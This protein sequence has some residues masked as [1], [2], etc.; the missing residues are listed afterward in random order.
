MAKKTA[1]RLINSERNAVSGA[2]KWLLKELQKAR[3]A[4][5]G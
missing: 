5:E 1:E 3:S 4:P 2:R